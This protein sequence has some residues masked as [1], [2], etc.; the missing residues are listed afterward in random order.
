MCSYNNPTVIQNLQSEDIKHAEEFVRT[1]L[2]GRLD[3][4]EDSEE[5]QHFFGG[6]KE[7]PTQFKFN[8][9][10]RILIEQMIERVKQIAKSPEGLQY[11]LFTANS[12][13]RFTR[14]IN[15]E[16]VNTSVGLFFCK[17]PSASTIQLVNRT[18]PKQSI[19]ELKKLLFQRSKVFF[20][21]S[22]E[23]TESSVEVNLLEPNQVEGSIVCNFC[24]ESSE[25]RKIK[26]F[27][28]LS[29]D[30][31]VSWV[32]SNVQTHINRM[33]SQKPNTK[34]ETFSDVTN[35]DVVIT[36]SEKIPEPYDEKSSFQPN[37][38]SQYE[39]VYS[40]SNNIPDPNANADKDKPN[41]MCQFEIDLTDQM[42]HFE[43]ILYTNIYSQQRII[44]HCMLQKN[45]QTTDFLFGTP[46]QQSNV[47]VKIGE[48]LRNGNCLFLALAHQLYQP[49]LN[50][51]KHKM[52]ANN[53]RKEVVEHI[54]TNIDK[55]MHDLKG[56]LLDN[57]ILDND[58][59][60]R[61]IQFVKDELS[62][63]TVWG[64]IETM[65]A[66]AAIHKINILIINDNKTSNLAN[67]FDAEYLRAV[68]LAYKIRGS[69]VERN[70]YDSVVHIEDDFLKES[71]VQAIQLEKQSL[72][73]QHEI[74]NSENFV[75]TC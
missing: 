75:I 5:K 27:C 2:S 56:R 49:N 71:V 1:E 29:N 4:R 34:E 28:R 44:K 10:E 70:H 65:K 19:G 58:M 53:L 46:Q 41:D 47:L 36:K 20:Q 11:F 35:E 32:L 61:C 57:S 22:S 66:V 68:A 21:G 40:E 52:L 7:N 25:S 73:F 74:L 33:H 13:K 31:K 72:I 62:Q 24:S 51:E 6:Y 64:G 63:E 8:R 26:V 59:N 18:P 17:L 50:S 39:I 42:K 54:L 69:V 23:F 45:Q 3:D 48:V 9:G 55:F 12:P 43:D 38:I 16:L 30:G 15:A 60:S 14:D 67:R 37:E